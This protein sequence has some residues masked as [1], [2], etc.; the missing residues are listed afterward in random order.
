MGNELPT[1][2][3]ASEFLDVTLAGGASPI[4]ATYGS[5]PGSLYTLGAPVV[6]PQSAVPEPAA[7]MPVALIFGSL[8]LRRRL[9]QAR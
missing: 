6:Q 7:F 4:V 1:N 8:V 5:A 3:P 9:A 2:G